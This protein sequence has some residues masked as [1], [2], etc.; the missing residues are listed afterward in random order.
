MSFK[1]FRSSSSKWIV[2]LF[3]LLLLAAGCSGNRGGSGKSYAMGEAAVVGPLTYHV[4]ETEWKQSLDG[5]MGQRLPK[6]Q[7]L[8]V[9]MTIAS[10]SEGEVGV[11][12][13][14]LIN[15]SGTEF[16][17]EDKG[18]GVSGW[19]GYLRRAGPDA[20]LSGRIV[21]DVPPG[22]YQLRISSGGPAETETTALVE[23]PFRADAPAVKGTDPLAAPPSK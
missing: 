11:P 12:F 1:K 4:V 2:A 18:E 22:G 10:K 17:E 14:T 13:L 16:R 6:H 20:P 5:S 9:N 23:L 8:L 15:A 21:F 7:F 3:G 19:L